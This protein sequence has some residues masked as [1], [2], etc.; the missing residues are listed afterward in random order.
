MATI[1]TAKQ[2]EVIRKII[3]AVETGGQIYGKQDYSSLIGAA[4]N[5]DNEKAITIG[6]GQ[7]YATEAQTL[8]NLI[9]TTDKST[10]KKLDTQG[11]AN[12]LDTK[13]WEFYNIAVSSA[14]AKCIVNIISSTVGIKCQDCL[15]DSQI[16]NYA[17]SIQKTYGSMTVDAIAE[18]INIKHQ[19]GDGALKRILAKTT[20]PYTARTIKA[21]LDTDLSDK[22]NNNQVGDYAS[23]QI[24]VY[25]MI[26]TYLLPLIENKN[27]GG[28]N[29]SVNKYIEDATVWMEETAGNDIHGYDQI[30]RW[31][32]KGDY[33]CSSAVITAWEKAGVKVKT[34]GATYTGNMLS[35]F[36]KMGF[37]DVTSSVNLSNGSG[38]KRGD[39]LLNTVHH[40]A[41]YCGSGKEVEASINE[42]GT[43]TNG[44]PGDQTG[45]E[46]LIRSYRNYPWTNVL[47][48]TGGVSVS[49]PTVSVL[50][51]GATGTAVKT[52]QTNLNKLINAGLVVDGDFGTKTYNAVINFQNKY[53][54][55]A[56]GEVGSQ[57]QGKIDELLKSISTPT[58][59]TKK[60]NIST[61]EWTGKVVVNED[62]VLNVRTWAGTEYP[63][64]KSYPVLKKGNRVVVKGSLKALDGSTWYKI[65]INNAATNYKDIIGFVSA[66]Y[67]KKV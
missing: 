45:K 40:T 39:V 5:T 34:A 26:N 25:E 42:K 6:A 48:Y 54:L 20:K 4:T 52:L 53:G 67:I 23:R 65:A 38:M 33:D 10:F 64:I 29:M 41:M 7:W 66:K 13:N 59:T 46:F 9:R 27:E 58:T 17:A 18:C 14:K 50:R 43:A 35:V 8:L 21:A 30:Y 60:T 49:I 63:N 55:I 22:S 12:D 36:K 56:D 1:L 62:D 47:R 32:E 2:K 19:G 31:G 24:K 15:M 44:I 37:V 11:I 57:T 28:V 61:K 51:K 16:T 3:Y